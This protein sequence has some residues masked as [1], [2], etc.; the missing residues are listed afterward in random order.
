MANGKGRIAR[1]KSLAA[2][3]AVF[4]ACVCLGPGFAG[5]ANAQEKFVTLG[6]SVQHVTLPPNE[7]LTLNTGQPFGD[8]VIGSADLIDVVP[9]SDRSL[10]IRGKK[11]GATNISVYADDKSLLGVIDIR[12]ASDFTEVAA[13]IRSAA[14]S[15]RVRVINSNDRIRLTG[16]VRDGIELQRVMEIAQSYSDQPVLNQLRVSD[17]QQVMLEVRVIEASRQTGRDLGIGWSG[18]GRNGIGKA[19]T[20]QGIGVNDDGSLV[21]TLLDPKG[22]ATGALPFGQLIAKVLEISGGQV[23][24]VINALE[25]KGLVRRLAQ[26]NLIAMS[27]STA[28]FH[29]GGEVPIL[30]TTNNGATVA[31]ETDYRP[32][33]VRLTFKPVVLDD[34]VIN[35]EIEPEVSELDPSINV[36][37]NPGFISRAAS[38]TVALRDGQSFAMAGLLQSINAK[39]IQQL[40]GLGKI[41]VLG[42]LF[43][44]TSFQK[45]ESDLVIVVT[46]HIVR[47]ARPGEDLYSPLDQT[48]SSNDVELFALGVME[49]DKDMLRRFRNGVGVTGPYGHRLDLNQGVQAVA[50]KR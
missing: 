42:A 41:P 3:A 39:D 37:G 30:K 47:P 25:Q 35:L 28:S 34:G 5:C 19:T 44:S 49:V 2:L 20:S 13:A 9:L 7:T 40:P 26:P 31:T 11:T 50:T 45:K 27:G 1:T 24:V 21:R 16:I 4:S 38:T 43:R 6:K 18:Q 29:A 12:V 23:D 22:A 32:F 15:A 10:F 8:L 36:N 46:P 48:R 14:P 33:G 17:S